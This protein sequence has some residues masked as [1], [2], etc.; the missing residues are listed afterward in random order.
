MPSESIFDWAKNVKL[1]TEWSLLHEDK[2]SIGKN[3]GTV[4]RY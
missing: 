3:T 4:L 2:E 1:C